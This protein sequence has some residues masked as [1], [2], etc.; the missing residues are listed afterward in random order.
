MHPGMD[1]SFM[2]CGHFAG[3]TTCDDLLNE[4]RAVIFYN[5]ICIHGP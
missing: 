1:A 5:I 3:P 2:F 4:V